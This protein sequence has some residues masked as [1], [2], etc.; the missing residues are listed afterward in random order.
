MLIGEAPGERED[1]TGQPF[2]GK[3][4]RLLVKALNQIGLLGTDVYVTNMVKCRPP[5]NRDPTFEEM[6]ACGRF[7]YPQIEILNPPRIGVLGRTAAAGLRLCQPTD[8]MAD[9]LGG[10][11][12][13]CGRPARVL[14]HPTYV[15]R[16]PRYYSDWLEELREICGL[17]K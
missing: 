3:A 9:I 2:V 7:L 16:N 12:E 5:D 15:G 6:T 4:G 10:G 14:L 11:Y 17:P 13:V 8:R 1:A